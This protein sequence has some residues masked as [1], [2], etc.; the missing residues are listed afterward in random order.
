MM[1]ILAIN[2]SPRKNWNTA[3]LLQSALK[4]ADSCGAIPEVRKGKK[5]KEV[6]F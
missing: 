1:Y 5:I 6:I 2:G 4:G 3:K